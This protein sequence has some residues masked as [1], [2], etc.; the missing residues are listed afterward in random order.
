[1]WPA[2]KLKLWFPEIG[3]LWAL[4]PIGLG[5]CFI[6]TWIR[7]VYLIWERE[8]R[9]WKG[10]WKVSK[11]SIMWACVSF[12]MYVNCKGMAR[13]H[14]NSIASTSST[15]GCDTGHRPPEEIA[16]MW[17][18]QCQLLS[19]LWCALGSCEP[20]ESR[21]SGWLLIAV[22]NCS[23]CLWG[24][25]LQQGGDVL[26]AVKLLLFG[27]HPWGAGGTSQKCG[28]WGNISHPPNCTT[29]AHR[30]TANAKEVIKNI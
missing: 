25:A 13:W 8:S 5:N 17:W 26:S 6:L 10:C 15:W 21:G 1:M 3:A 23:K 2:L 9:G 24:G 22:C 4:H 29:E 14:I 20:E 12:M 30:H 28:I 11:I 19:G 27:I 16:G 7:A 18:H